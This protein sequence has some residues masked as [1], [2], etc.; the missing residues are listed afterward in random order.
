[1]EVSKKK[2]LLLSISNNDR[3][4]FNTFYNLYYDQVFRFS[5]FFLRNKEACKEIVSEV[6]F[7]VWQ[8]RKRLP[9]I[10]NM[11]AWLY[12]II[13]N[14]A[15]RYSINRKKQEEISLSGI[16]VDLQEKGERTPE[17]KLLDKE[18][19][20]LLNK[21]INELPERCRI[22]FLMARQDGLKPKEIAEILSINESTVR[23][24]MKI[25]VEKIIQNIKP[26]FPHLLLSLIIFYLQDISGLL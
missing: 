10:E 19:E 26:H 21:A 17:D 16:S 3:N 18:I 25:A 14:E 15:N 4:A 22:I 2:E 1:M 23:V 12:V 6:F 7:S 5:F 24:Q 11:E 20:E 13:K 8:A 9:D